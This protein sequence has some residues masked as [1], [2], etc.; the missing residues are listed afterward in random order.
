MI[1]P[2]N[3]PHY[4]LF[5]DATDGRDTFTDVACG[6]WCFLLES[7]GDAHEIEASDFEPNIERERLELLAVVRGLEALDQPSRVTL[8]TPSRYVNRGIRF[9]LDTW[10]ESNWKWE[11]YGLLKPVKNYDLWQRI[12]RAMEIHQVVCRRWR[13][14]R[15][16]DG[17]S[18]AN[19][20]TSNSNVKPVDLAIEPAVPDMAAAVG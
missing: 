9:G 5:T 18:L 13:L 20:S 2:A 11:A 8:V 6:Q 4:L 19:P 12:D 10:R 17:G 1:A 16:D 15:G 7:L 3:V 14:D